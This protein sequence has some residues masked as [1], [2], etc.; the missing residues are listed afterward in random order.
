VTAIVWRPALDAARTSSRGS[1]EPSEIV[2][3][4]CRS[5]PKGTP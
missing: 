2:V 4:V 1:S 3:C 5:M